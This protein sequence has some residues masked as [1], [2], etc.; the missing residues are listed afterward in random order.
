MKAPEVLNH[1]WSFFVFGPPFAIFGGRIFRRV[2]GFQRALA[3]L[4][5]RGLF[6]T[7][8]YAACGYDS[9]FVSSYAPPAICDV[10][11]FENYHRVRLFGREILVRRTI[12][13]SRLNSLGKSRRT[14]LPFIFSSF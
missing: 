5:D 14:I 6:Y 4:I 13:R 11:L 9:F 7:T 2:Q 8:V 12:R 1:Q 10:G 3:E